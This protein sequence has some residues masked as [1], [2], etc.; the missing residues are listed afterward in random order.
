MKPGNS[1]C[2]VI[3]VGLAAFCLPA[4]GAQAEGGDPARLLPTAAQGKQWT[5]KGAPKRL[6]GDQIYDY[7]DGAG[8]IPL[9]CGYQTLIVA[10]YAGQAGG[11]ITIELY[12]MGNSANAFGLYSMKR[13]PNGRTVAMGTHTSP[14]QAEAG[15]HELLCHKG[16]YTLLLFGDESGK[17]KDAD[18]LALGTA[19]VGGIKES[20]VPPDLLRYLPQTGYVAK[21]AKYF[22]GKA[23]MDMVKFVRDDVFRFKARPEAAVAT[24]KNPPGKLMVIRY[25]STSEAGQALQ[26][27]QQS[28]GTKGMT[29][30]QQGRLV[31]AV[32]GAPH[33]PVDAALIERL[34][35]AL[36][37]PGPLLE[38]A[39]TSR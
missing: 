29:F 7:M 25:G 17:V 27:A 13:L 33:K 21:T 24:Y 39:P 31:G 15:Y 34:K 12:D 11:V 20:G 22:H 1:M 9:A 3:A 36:Q 32:W 28:S 18:L 35:R 10:E 16:R 23:A 5:P 19:L 8:E 37:K 26:A 14:I 2:F 38:G 30:V 4:L 6:T